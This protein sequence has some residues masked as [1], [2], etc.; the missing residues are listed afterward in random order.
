MLGSRWRSGGRSTE[1]HGLL[2]WS[3]RIM[4]GIGL[5]GCDWLGCRLN[6]GRAGCGGRDLP[7]QLSPS[8]SCSSRGCGLRCRWSGLNRYRLSRR[9]FFLRRPRSG[10]RTWNGS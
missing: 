1:A 8:G 5:D 6:R 10:G 7:R 4:G 3:I 2:I 9:G